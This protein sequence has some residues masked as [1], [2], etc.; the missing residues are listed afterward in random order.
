MHLLYFFLDIISLFIYVT[1][2]FF[3]LKEFVPLRFQNRALYAVEVVCLAVV[4]NAIVYPEEVTGTIGSLIGLLPVLVLFHKGKWY[5]KLTAALIVYP[6]M[7]SL[8]FLFQDI[9]QQIWEHVFHMEMSALGEDTLYLLARFVKIPAWY[10]I[11]RCVKVWVPRAVRTLTERMWLVLS[12][13]ALASFTGIIIIIYKCNYDDSYLAW[14]A[15]IATLVTSMG[16]CYLCTYMEKIVRSDMELEAMR[17]Q[18]TYYEEVEN[19]QQTVRR[20]RHDIKNHLGVIETLLRERAYDRAEEYLH[21][22]EQETQVKTKVYCPDSVVNAVLNAKMQKAQEEGIECEYRIDLKESPSMDEIDICSLFSNTLDNA[23]EAC[24]KIA[25]REKRRIVLKARSVEGNFSYGIVNSKENRIIER[26]GGLE[27]DK[28]DRLSHGIGLRSV[29]Q[30]VEKYGGETE[31]GYTED[32]FRVTV[33]V[34][35]IKM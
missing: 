30:I 35:A 22:L 18:K 7:M 11:Y 4:G 28:E 20:I 8:A 32:T 29:R 25:E 13:I 34:P 21:S 10:V 33:F 31:V 17:Y 26:N 9:S 12:M 15:C 1:L 23:I 27:T 24:M 14:P 3:I 5:M 6:A 16:C 19:S 2:I